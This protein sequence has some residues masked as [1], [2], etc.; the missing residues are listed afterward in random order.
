MERVL[1]PFPGPRPRPSI[2]PYH[3]VPDHTLPYHTSPLEKHHHT[4][5]PYH[6]SAPNPGACSSSAAIRQSSVSG[7]D[8][9]Y[10]RPIVW[11]DPNYPRPILW[12]IVPMVNYLA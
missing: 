5:I 8:P 4:S 12:P 1:K 11:P 7:A 2:V 3:T 6:A 9:N 10:P